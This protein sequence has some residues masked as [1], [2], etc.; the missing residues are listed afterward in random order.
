MK[1]SKRL[2]IFFGVCLLLFSGCTQYNELVKMNERQRATIQSLTM[3][4]DRLNQDLDQ[5]SQAQTG[6]E[7]TKEDLER[8]LQEQIKSG[9][10]DIEMRNRGL[11]VTILNNILFDSGK[12]VLKNTAKQ[13]LS[14]IGNE[15][16]R[17]DDRQIV[18]VEGHTDSDPIKRS[19]FRSNWE[20]STARATEVIHYLMEGVKVSPKRLAAVG[21]GEHRPVATNKTAQGKGKNRRVEIIISP[22]NRS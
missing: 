7:K 5:V 14:T 10:L 9:D 20:L 4:I 13:T 6:L 17:L 19:N 12:S 1:V 15:I 18:Y 22:L 21:Y 8:Q 11:V 16:N 2:P 3:E